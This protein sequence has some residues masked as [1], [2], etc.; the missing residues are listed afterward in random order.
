M[1]NGI[2]HSLEEFHD[3]V[4]MHHRMREIMHHQ[5]MLINMLGLCPCLYLSRPSGRRCLSERVREFMVFFQL[6]TLLV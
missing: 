6:R 1:I 5:N 4:A 3:I 2:L